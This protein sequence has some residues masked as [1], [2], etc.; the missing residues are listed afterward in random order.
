MTAD[1]TLQVAAK[2][3][4]I[5]HGV[6]DTIPPSVNFTRLQYGGSVNVSKLGQF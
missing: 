2:L 3:H 6:V 1:I 4:R 5:V